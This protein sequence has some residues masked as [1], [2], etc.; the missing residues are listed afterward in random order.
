MAAG[1]IAQRALEDESRVF[2]LVGIIP[3]RFY[4]LIYNLGDEQ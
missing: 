3:P 1:R 2:T 4:T